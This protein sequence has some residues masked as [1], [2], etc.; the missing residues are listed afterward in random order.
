MINQTMGAH[1]GER[2]R[3]KLSKE[4]I[5]PPPLRRYYLNTK[6]KRTAMLYAHTMPV[7]VGW[8]KIS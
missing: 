1:K 8:I 3:D 5:I 2:I 6:A 7:R 4:A